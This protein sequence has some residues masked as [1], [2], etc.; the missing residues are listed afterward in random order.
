MQGP[1]SPCPVTPTK[2]TGND[3]A[4]HAELDDENSEGED[5]LDVE[6]PQ[7]WKRTSTVLSYDV[8]KRWATGERAEKDDDVIKEE[9]LEE[10][11]NLTQLS[12][13]KKFPYHK[14]LDS[15]LG[16]WKHAHTHT[17]KHNVKF[18]V[19]RC[20]LRYRCKCF[21]CIRVVTSADYIEI[22]S[23]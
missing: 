18:E 8:V 13:Q 21:C 23:S 14:S 9:L 16:V 2:S 7:K 11:R 15:D 20:P 1:E 5:D 10:V 17:N 12:L 22:Q 4:V 19:Y 6:L 3:G